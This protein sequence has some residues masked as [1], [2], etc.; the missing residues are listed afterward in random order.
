MNRQADEEEEEKSVVPSADA[1]G[2]PWTVMIESLE[3]ID[4]VRVRR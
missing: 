4:T 3:K 1:V 2:H